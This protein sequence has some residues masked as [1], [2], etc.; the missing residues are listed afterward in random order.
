[1]AF[2][3]YKCDGCG[4]MFERMLPISERH[5]PEQEACD[6]CGKYEIRKVETGIL[7]FNADVKPKLDSGF[8]EISRRIKKANRHSNMPEY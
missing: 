6:I 1:M 2:Y 8:K 3:D 4:V 5:N 7:G